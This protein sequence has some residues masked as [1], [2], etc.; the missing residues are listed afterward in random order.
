L[1]E[2]KEAAKGKKMKNIARWIMALLIAG[3]TIQSTVYAS[4]DRSSYSAIEAIEVSNQPSYQEE[5]SASET[6]IFYLDALPLDASEEAPELSMEIDFY[7]LA[8]PLKGYLVTILLAAQ[9]PP[10]AI[11]TEKSAS[12]ENFPELKGLSGKHKHLNEIKNRG[13]KLASWKVAKGVVFY[14]WYHPRLGTFL[15]PDFRPPNIYDPSTFTEPYA[16]ATGN[17]VMYWD[18][19]GLAELRM[20][21]I[22]PN[23][24]EKKWIL[25]D[26]WQLIEALQGN[27]FSYK[28]EKGKNWIGWPKWSEEQTHPGF[29]VHNSS[30]YLLAQLGKEVFQN[31]GV[32]PFDLWKPNRTG[33]KPYQEIEILFGATTSV[34]GITLGVEQVRLKG[35]SGTSDVPL[36]DETALFWYFGAGTSDI[37]GTVKNYKQNLEDF[38]QVILD[39]THIVD[40]GPLDPSSKAKIVKLFKTLGKEAVTNLE[41]YVGE[42]RRTLSNWD[43]VRDLSI[44]RTSPVFYDPKVDWTWVGSTTNVSPNGIRELKSIP[45]P[46]ARAGI[47][48]YKMIPDLDATKE[49]K[50]FL[51]SYTGYFATGGLGYGPVSMN[52]FYGN[53]F[54]DKNLPNFNQRKK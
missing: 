27:S 50:K 51:K 19:D 52:L 22:D 40:Q 38:H 18:L 24:Q 29:G 3:S 20:E 5:N 39:I 35:F 2:R 14:R 53:P 8:P 28:H 47:V 23:T 42:G 17:P 1:K 44:I 31:N 21:Y 7:Q 41:G 12:R 54:L 32:Q 10:Y 48:F 16:Y 25:I 4:I 6:P 37:K 33:G 13:C 46:K 36:E 11:S 15:T 9:P 45:K 34:K 49:Q 26:W 43:D 30:E